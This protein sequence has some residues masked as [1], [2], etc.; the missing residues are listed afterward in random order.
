MK[1]AINMK[2]FGTLS[3]LWKFVDKYGMRYEDCI[4]FAKSHMM[5]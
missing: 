3:T 5:I 1:I 2:Y 4:Y